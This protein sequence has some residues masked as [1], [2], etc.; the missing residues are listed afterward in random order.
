MIFEKFG[1]ALNLAR[2][3]HREAI[4]DMVVDQGIKVIFL[5]NLSTLASGLREND[6][7]EWEGLGNWFLELRR[8]KLTVILVHHAGRNGLMRGTSKRED[9]AAWILSLASDSDAADEGAQFVSHFAK[10]PRV[11]ADNLHDYLWKFTTD[12]DTKEVSVYWEK[13]QP[14]DR[15][16]ALVESGV[17]RNAEIAEELGI[18]AGAVSKLA[19]KAVIA[20]WLAVKGREYFPKSDHETDG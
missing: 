20:G 15:F 2:Q 1:K 19:K 6:S 14:A 5:D 12:E 3:E 8:L 13:A 4:R 9:M 17:S 16:R 10:R 7:R 18:T 11:M